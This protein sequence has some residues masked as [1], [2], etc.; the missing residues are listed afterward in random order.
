M[1]SAGVKIQLCAYVMCC[2]EKYNISINRGFILYGRKGQ[3]Y[4]ICIDEKLRIKTIEVVGKI[5][6]IIDFSVLSRKIPSETPVKPPENFSSLQETKS[7]N[8]E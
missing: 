1:C 8:Q 2:E 4:E 6:K 5:K 7:L 3:T